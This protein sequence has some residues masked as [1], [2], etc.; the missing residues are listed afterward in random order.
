[1][2]YICSLTPCECS[3][4][5]QVPTDNLYQLHIFIDQR[6]LLVVD[7]IHQI[8]FCRIPKVASSSWLAKLKILKD[9]LNLNKTFSYNE[10]ITLHEESQG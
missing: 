1:M 4:R 7:P 8:G 9:G 10:V 6:C 5:A 2:K 3:V